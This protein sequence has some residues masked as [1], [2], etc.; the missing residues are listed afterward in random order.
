MCNALV[1]RRWWSFQDRPTI[2]TMVDTVGLR[3][4]DS[5]MGGKDQPRRTLSASVIPTFFHG[6]ALLMS[7]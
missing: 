6:Q 1:M 2:L 4:G 3:Q 7:F 5:E